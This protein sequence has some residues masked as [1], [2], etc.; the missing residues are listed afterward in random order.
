MNANKI[1]NYLGNEFT[2]SVRKNDIPYITVKIGRGYDG[3]L[4]S[5]TMEDAETRLGNMYVHIDKYYI[6]RVPEG[7]LEYLKK[8]GAQLA[9]R[10]RKWE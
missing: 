4:S 6:D 8:N 1:L 5:L 9:K 7:T 2:C 10:S 3:K